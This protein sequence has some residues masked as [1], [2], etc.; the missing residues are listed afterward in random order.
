MLDPRVQAVVDLNPADRLAHY[1]SERST[2]VAQLRT[3]Q[4]YLRAS[5]TAEDR[6]KS[7]KAIET[8]REWLT[9]LD[10]AIAKLRG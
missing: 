4:D 9:L 3:A 6:A 5:R 8:T 7:R 1:L 2:A 10:A